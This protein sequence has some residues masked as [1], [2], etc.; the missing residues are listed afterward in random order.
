MFWLGMITGFVL[1]FAISY[2]IV[3]IKEY[4]INKALKNLKKGE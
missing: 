2:A 4:K 1:L 3:K